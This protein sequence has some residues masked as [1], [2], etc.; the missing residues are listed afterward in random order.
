MPVPDDHYEFEVPVKKSKFLLYTVIAL[1]A[2]AIAYFVL[3][4]EP[5]AGWPINLIHLLVQH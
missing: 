4:A 1:A 3:A 5:P 2:V